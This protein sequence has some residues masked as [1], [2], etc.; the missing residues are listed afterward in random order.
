MH[1][2]HATNATNATNDRCFFITGD[3]CRISYRLDGAAD[4]PVLVLSNSIAT[5]LDMWEGQMDALA[6]R[7]RVLRY[8]TRGHG[9]SDAPDGPYSMDRLGRDVL[10]LLD[11]LHIER[12][13]FCG[14]SLGGLIGQWLGIHAPDRIERLIL[15]NT[16]PY[17]GPP[18]QWDRLIDSIEA[19]QDGAQLAAMFIGNWFP[20][21]MIEA[22]LPVVETFRKMV[23]GT[24]AHG[25]AGCFAAIRDVDLRRTIA[26]VRCPTL[27]IAGQHDTVTLASHGESIAATIPDAR[28]IILPAVHLSNV[29]HPA[30]FVDAVVEFLA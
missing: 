22:R 27:V 5:T 11:A 19:G 30:R 14:L 18:P 6:Q 21:P 7:F 10:E 28:L 1:A 3:G 23:L 24:P 12:A 17:L 13:H 9:Q 2:M 16:S 26:L 15:C 25:L 8:D 20:R 4:R 29:E